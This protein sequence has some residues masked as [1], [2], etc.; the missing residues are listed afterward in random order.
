MPAKHTPGPWKL[1]LNKFGCEAAVTVANKNSPDQPFIVAMC[2][3]GEHLNN[4]A[5]A[6]LIAAAPEMLKA[7]KQLYSI[8][9]DFNR[10]SFD[11]N[12]IR[13]ILDKAIAKAEGRDDAS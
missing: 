10:T 7:I 5:N 13:S 12:E 4:E 3:D 9:M 11:L 2:D 1:V 8:Y 6:R